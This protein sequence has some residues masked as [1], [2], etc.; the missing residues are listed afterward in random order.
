MIAALSENN[1]CCVY[2]KGDRSH[3]C[4]KGCDFFAGELGI[5]ETI[6]ERNMD[7]FSFYFSIIRKYAMIS[8]SIFIF[9]LYYNVYVKAYKS[10]IYYL[11]YL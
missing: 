9:L 5:R 2:Y 3:G 6:F 7:F 8:F 1:Q 11:M 4:E 10:D